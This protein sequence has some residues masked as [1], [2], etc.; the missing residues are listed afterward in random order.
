MNLTLSI[1][2][3]VAL[4]AGILILVVP[5]LLNYIVAIYL[6]YTRTCY[7]ALLLVAPVYFVIKHKLMKIILTGVA[8]GVTVLMVHLFSNNY[9]LK[10]APDFQ[11][12]IIHDE[13]GEH[14][15]STLEGKDVSS[16]ERVY[17]WVAATRMFKDHPLMG[18]GPGNFYPYY[19]SYTLTSFE[20]YVSDNPERSTAHNYPLLLLAEQGTIGLAIFLFLTAV[21]FIYGE[22]IYHRVKNEDDKKIALTLLLVLAMVYVNLLLSDLLESDKVGPFYFIC[23]ALLAT[24]DIR[25]RQLLKTQSE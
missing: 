9:Y 11:E 14:L 6:S 7:I 3:I 15:S 19:K 20:T 25:N 8:I 22:N 12:T 21:I 18:F 17:R 24:I 10:Y 2:P 16:M 13:F 1:G 23:I 5:R 4:I